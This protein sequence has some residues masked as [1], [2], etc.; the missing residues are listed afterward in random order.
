M[1]FLRLRILVLVA[2]SGC[3]LVS[4]RVEQ[5]G[6]AERAQLASLER[7]DAAA[8]ARDPECLADIIDHASKEL[9]DRVSIQQSFT[10]SARIIGD[11]DGDGIAERSVRIESEK[12]CIDKTHACL[13]YVYSSN[14]GCTQ[15]LG[16]SFAVKLRPIATATGAR[17]LY[18]YQIERSPSE[19]R[20]RWQYACHVQWWPIKDGNFDR[21]G[22]VH[23]GC[24]GTPTAASEGMWP[25]DPSV[26]EPFRTE[27]RLH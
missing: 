2:V 8:H 19:D 9:Q 11:V 21:Q 6:D 3:F 20:K 4:W 5:V 16:Q 10:I 12:T 14:R 25:D 13:F 22:L 15:Y 24:D 1:V 26:C 27:I 23:C 18:A 7:A 17:Y